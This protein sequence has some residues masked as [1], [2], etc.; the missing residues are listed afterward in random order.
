MTNFRAVRVGGI[1]P[2]VLYRSN[3]PVPEAGEIKE[4][5]ALARAAG[6]K[7]VINLIDDAEGLKIAAEK[8]SW[9]GEMVRQYRVLALNLGID[10]CSDMFNRKLRRGLES[11][12]T[13]PG[14]YLI[15]C[16]AGVDRTGFVCALLEAFMGATFQEI[17]ADYSV[18]FDNGAMSAVHHGDSSTAGRAI[19]KQLSK[20]SP[21]IR[22]NSGTL[23]ATA[24]RYLVET[25]R[26]ES[27]R[28][29]ALKRRL[30]GKSYGI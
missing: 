7:T 22:L 18:S 15:H 1:G 26:L 9:Y 3:H 6:I 12:T 11:M 4:I 2:G 28:V 27:M 13:N 23:Q 30:A 5:A 14:P 25:L 19:L 17:V 16:L 8:S 29:A 20:I 10:F 21:G 24:E